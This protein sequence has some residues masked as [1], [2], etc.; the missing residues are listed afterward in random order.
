M[1]AKYK[2]IG[3]ALLLTLIES[4]HAQHKVKLD[5]MSGIN[6]SWVRSKFLQGIEP[7]FGFYLGASG[8]IK[9]REK[10]SFSLNYLVS[11]KGYT[12][13]LDKEYKVQFTYLEL[14][15]IAN[16]HLL[17]SVSLYGG[18]DVSILA[19]VNVKKWL[20]TYNSIDFSLVGGIRFFDKT[21]VT[22]NAQ[23]VYG[24]IPVLNYYDIDKLGNLTSIKDVKNICLSVGIRYRII[25]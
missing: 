8:T 19:N 6:Y 9:A 1:K 10:L 5:V 4:V 2:L 22:F 21:P 16:Y 25:K 11:R 3:I 15:A 17:K 23:I 12:Q 18:S 14:Q 20:R 13:F 7:A 24:L